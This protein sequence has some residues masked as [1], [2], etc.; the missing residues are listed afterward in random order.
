[1]GNELFTWSP[2]DVR[3]AQCRDVYAAE[4]QLKAVT[5]LCLLNRGRL[6]VDKLCFCSVD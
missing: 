6:E 1:M 3:H 5:H 4:L 2:S